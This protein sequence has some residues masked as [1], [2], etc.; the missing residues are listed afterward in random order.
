[1]SQFQLN[2]FPAAGTAISILPSNLVLY[3]GNT[4]ELVFGTIA[5]T[6]IADTLDLR[7]NYYHTGQGHGVFFAAR[8]RSMRATEYIW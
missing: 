1:V 3:N 8:V 2:Y 7:F 6:T 4:N 5:A